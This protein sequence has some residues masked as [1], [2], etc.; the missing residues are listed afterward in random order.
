M[1]TFIDEHNVIDSERE[2]TLKNLFVE[3][4]YVYVPHRILRKQ[5]PRT[6]YRTW[7]ERFFSW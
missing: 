6:D 4:G 7:F 5:Y 1:I 3:F 2:K